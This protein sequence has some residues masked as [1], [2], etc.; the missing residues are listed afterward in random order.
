[1]HKFKKTLNSKITSVVYD[2]PNMATWPC[3]ARC[4]NNVNYVMHD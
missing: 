3:V 4:I 1:M 2:N